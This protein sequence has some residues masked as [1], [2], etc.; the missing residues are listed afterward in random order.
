MQ[1]EPTF[2]IRLDIDG[3]EVP[4]TRGRGALKKP[5]SPQIYESIPSSKESAQPSIEGWIVLV[6]GVHEEASEEDVSDKFAEYGLIRNCH[7]NL[8]RRTG[9]VMGYA[10]IEYQD[11]DEAKRAIDEADGTMLLGKVVSCNFAFVKGD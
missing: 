3:E 2:K 8:N 6:T 9:Y 10:L 5:T 1:K 11:Y 4:E 7:L